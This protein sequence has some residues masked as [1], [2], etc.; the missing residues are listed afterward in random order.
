MVHI[1]LIRAVGFVIDDSRVSSTSRTRASPCQQAWRARRPRQCPAQSRALERLHTC[2]QKEQTQMGRHTP[3]TV[4][5]TMLNSACRSLA[6]NS[7]PRRKIAIASVPSTLSDQPFRAHA[8]PTKI[9]Y[10][11]MDSLGCFACSG[12]PCRRVPTTATDVH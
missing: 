2:P 7:R 1:V 8:R 12:R 6:T 5:A 4:T 9:L 10:E 3:A 11:L